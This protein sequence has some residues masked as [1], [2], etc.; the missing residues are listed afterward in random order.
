MSV[1]DKKR[2]AELEFMLAAYQDEL[3]PKLNSRIEELIAALDNAVE[4]VRCE[5][6]IH[7]SDD[8]GIE[9]RVCLKIYSDGAA[10]TYAWQKRKFDD[11]CSYG[12]R[13]E[14]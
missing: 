2:I 13:R 1:A 10:S 3:I 12:K 6:C 8:C 7:W 5:E 9:E 4:V 11:F 14:S